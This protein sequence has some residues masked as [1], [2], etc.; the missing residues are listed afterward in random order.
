MIYWFLQVY[1]SGILY[2]FWYTHVSLDP[3]HTHYLEY[4][5]LRM[6]L[7]WVLEYVVSLKRVII[8]YFLVL[9]KYMDLIIRSFIFL[10]KYYTQYDLV[11]EDYH[12][13]HSSY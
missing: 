12:T 1:I 4:A 6:L 5:C 2:T 11:I 7:F 10:I 3:R 13:R 9:F 8:S